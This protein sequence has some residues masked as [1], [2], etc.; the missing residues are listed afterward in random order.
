MPLANDANSDNRYLERLAGPPT[1]DGEVAGTVGLPSA[2]L[3]EA[4][5]DALVVL[6]GVEDLQAPIEQDGNAK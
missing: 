4:C 1:C 5:V 2:V 3:S 6:G